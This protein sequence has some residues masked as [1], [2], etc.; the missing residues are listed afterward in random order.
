M[1]SVYEMK[2]RDEVNRLDVS[3]DRGLRPEDDVLQCLMNVGRDSFNEL[4]TRRIYRE[5]EEACK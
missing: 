4:R 3:I 5:E 1:Y 2:V